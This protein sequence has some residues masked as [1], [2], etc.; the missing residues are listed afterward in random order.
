MSGEAFLDTGSISLVE[1]ETVT[2]NCT[3]VGC[4]TPL[5]TWQFSGI[6]NSRF[7]EVDA[8]LHVQVQSH[9]INSTRSYSVLTITNA[10]RTIHGSFR[11]I[12]NNGVQK[13]SGF[14]DQKTINVYCKFSVCSTNV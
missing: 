5:I 12:A 7:T 6:G 9:V 10:D 11:C 14:S 8:D 13:T 1:G 3:A 2:F 4:P